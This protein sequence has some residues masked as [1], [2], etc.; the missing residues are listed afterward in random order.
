MGKNTLV[1]WSS[2]D[3]LNLAHHCPPVPY[4][5][6]NPLLVGSAIIDYG[7]RNNL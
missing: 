7:L 3:P 5:L 4:L 2:Q 6:K 1:V